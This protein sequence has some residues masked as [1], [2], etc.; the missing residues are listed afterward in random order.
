M[1]N[2]A[3][4]LIVGSLLT[5]V[6]GAREAQLI[7]DLEAISSSGQSIQIFSQLSP[8]QINKIHGWQIVVRAADGE[9]VSGAEISVSGGM[10][11]HDHGIPT[12]PRI[13]RQLEPGVYLLKGVRFH[14]PGKWQLVVEIEQPGQTGRAVIEFEL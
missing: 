3:L 7:A 5:A 10:P 9:P 6:A 4:W 2:K 1:R 11:E 8:L 12:Q 13:T 14:M